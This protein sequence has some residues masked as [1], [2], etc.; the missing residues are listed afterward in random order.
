M[1]E[2]QL[3]I[4]ISYQYIKSLRKGLLIDIALISSLTI[5]TLFDAYVYYKTSTLSPLCFIG[6]GAIIA[7]IIFILSLYFQKRD[8]LKLEILVLKGHKNRRESKE[9]WE[10]LESMLKMERQYIRMIEQ[11][12]DQLKPTDASPENK[13]QESESQ[14][15][16]KS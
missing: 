2:L 15:A 5:I 7:N 10:I 1:D 3:K 13:P 6:L 16:G 9:Y 11:I 12:E 4:D 8:D 14:G